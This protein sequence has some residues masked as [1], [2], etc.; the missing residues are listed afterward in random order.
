VDIAEKDD[1]MIAQCG[2]Q[3]VEWIRRRGREDGKDGEDG[4]ADGEQRGHT[5]IV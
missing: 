2:L 5:S 3:E 1:S 4:K